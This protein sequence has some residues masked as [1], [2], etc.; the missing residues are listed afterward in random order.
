MPSTS[1]PA[2]CAVVGGTTVQLGFVPPLSF[3]QSSPAVAPVRPLAATLNV[4]EKRSF[5]RL[6]GKAPPVV[7]AVVMSQ[8]SVCIVNDVVG[9]PTLGEGVAGQVCAAPA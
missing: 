5:S 1:T 4:T 7:S 8:T 2:V 3:L 6:Y 9:A